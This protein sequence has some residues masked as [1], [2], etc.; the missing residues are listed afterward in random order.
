MFGCCPK[1]QAGV[2]ADHLL[3]AVILNT[4]GGALRCITPSCTPLDWAVR[5]CLSLPQTQTEY[6]PCLKWGKVLELYMRYKIQNGV[7]EALKKCVTFFTLGG[8]GQD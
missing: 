5:W 8:E 4:V 7:R 1:T 2:L 6:S 3:L